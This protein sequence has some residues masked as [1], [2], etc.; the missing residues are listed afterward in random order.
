LVASLRRRLALAHLA[1]I[2]LVLGVAALGGYLWLA[3]AV[4][5]HLD[6]ELMT[7]AETEAGMLAANPGAPVQVH[8]IAP[9]A[10]TPFFT[11]LDRLV[12]IVDA[13][14]E[15]LA[16]S[17]N[18]GTAR[19]PTPPALLAALP[20]SGPVFQSLTKFGQEPVRM[21]TVPS[22]SSGKQYAVQ[23]AGSL[24][25]AERTMESAGT[26][27]AALGAA[28]LIALGLAGALATGGVFNAIQ[29]VVAQARRIGEANLHERLPH[30]G[31]QDEIGRLVGT[32]NAMLERLEQAFETQ[33]RFTA[34]ASHELRSPLSRLRMELEVTLRRPRAAPEYVQALRSCMDE[35]ERLTLLVDELLLL[36]RMDASRG[37]GT[38]T[39]ALDAVARGVLE[40]LGQDIAG[41]RIQLVLDAPPPLV[42]RIG[43]GSAEL[44]LS[45]LLE[46]A[47]KFSGPDG[48]VQ[49][50]LGRQDGMATVSVTDSG[51]GIHDQDLPHLFDRFY[52]GS[53]ARSSGAPGVGL[54][55]ALS[56]DIARAHGGHIAAHNQPGGGATFTFSLPAQP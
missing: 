9:S 26:L 42:A 46:N 13:R 7:L 34:D 44:V 8:E 17:A 49:L 29:R 5:E 47:L 19:L 38:E 23:V 15:V 50:R 6:H 22:S 14:G 52:R 2:V 3:R 18:L 33:R 56:Q 39:V 36:A 27:F 53:A 31:T 30:P 35:V 41:Q 45:N 4:H 43:H 54:G 24:D 40:R 37:A 32:L 20:D 28:L 11:R 21:V 16:R 48:R 51:P 25:D 12:Q 10:T 55:L 1:A